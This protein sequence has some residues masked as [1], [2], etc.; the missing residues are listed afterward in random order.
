MYVRNPRV[1]DEDD[2]PYEEMIIGAVNGL[3][4][5]I[6]STPRLLYS[7]FNSNGLG[8]RMQHSLDE[9]LAADLNIPVADPQEPP[10]SLPLEV[11]NPMQLQLDEAEIDLQ[12]HKLLAT[13]IDPITREI[14]QNPVV[15]NTGEIVEES[16]AQMSCDMNQRLSKGSVIKSYVKVEALKQHIEFLVADAIK[17]AKLAREPQWNS[18]TLG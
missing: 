5:M 9:L 3:G 7:F 15:T 8:Q 10:L 18:P 4:R 16:T 1:N 2:V 13:F 14:I 17:E 6:S 12:N 11:A